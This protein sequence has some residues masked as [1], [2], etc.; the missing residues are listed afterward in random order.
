MKL[1]NCKEMG[2]QLCWRNVETWTGTE[3][4]EME[5]LGQCGVVREQS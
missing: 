1:N 5:F 4:K 2:R 3:E